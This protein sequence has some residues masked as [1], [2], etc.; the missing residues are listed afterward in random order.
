MLICQGFAE[1][2]KHNHAELQSH[3]TSSP[4]QDNLE[5]RRDD[6]IKGSSNNPWQEVFPEITAKIRERSGDI[7]DVLTAR[8]STTTTVEQTAFQIALMD[9]AQYYFQYRLRSSC[10]IPSITLEGTLQDWQNLIERFKRLR[11]FGMEGWVDTLL[12]VLQEF[13]QPGVHREFWQSIY[14]FRSRSGG[15]EITGW[16]LQFFP[17]VQKK[18]HP[19]A[20]GEPPLPDAKPLLD[21]RLPADVSQAPFRWVFPL[22]DQTFDM[23]FVAGFFGMTHDLQTYAVRPA[24]GWMVAE[25]QALNQVD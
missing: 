11:D 22:E 17:Y 14:K 21:S 18:R 10:G 7:V 1:H 6:F 4:N 3:F 13:T 20:W 25:T 24:I 19:V 15:E 5:V 12:P 2:V 8:Y 23:Q 9:A 16:I